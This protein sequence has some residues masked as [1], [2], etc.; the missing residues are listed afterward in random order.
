VI[1]LQTAKKRIANTTVNWDKAHSSIEKIAD[2]VM[3]WRLYPRKEVDHNVV[4]NY[5][6]AML[7]GSAFP[8]VKIGIFA[9][10]KII[11]DGVHRVSARKQ[12]K[13][14]YIDSAVMKFDSEALLFA[15]AV[16]LNSGHGKTFT[17]AELDANIRKLKKYKFNV[18]EIQ[19]IVHVPASEITREFTRPITHITLPSG[20]R[21][22]CIEVKP[23]EAG[24]HG[25]ICL[26]SALFIVCRW[27]EAG[28]I[29]SE[30]PFKELAERIRLALQKVRF[31][32]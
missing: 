25:L 30:P 1:E 17:E 28:K 15:E 23:G 5:A 27:A 14:E 6:N 2:L 22:A 8:R 10:K 7:S 11:V 32:A 13:I 9:R 19:S 20:K 3:D 31:N 26:K 4:N 16:R 18:N 29:P 24:V 12:L 21:K